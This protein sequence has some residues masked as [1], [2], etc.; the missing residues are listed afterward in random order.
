MI[1]ENDGEIQQGWIQRE[2]KAAAAA[3]LRIVSE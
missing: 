1:G 3:A 2:M